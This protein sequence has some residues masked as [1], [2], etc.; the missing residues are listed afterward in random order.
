MMDIS[1]FAI[2]AVKEKYLLD[3]LLFQKFYQ[4]HQTVYLYKPFSIS[5]ATKLLF[6]EKIQSS[7]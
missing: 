4:L 3:I 2:P 6:R 5:V 7:L 1:F